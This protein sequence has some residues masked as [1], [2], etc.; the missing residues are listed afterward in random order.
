[1]TDELKAYLEKDVKAKLA[2]SI[3]EAML[4]VEESL[5]DK[6][7]NLSSK[8]IDKTLKS[9]QATFILELT[10]MLDRKLAG[11]SGDLE[12]LRA[13]V[14]GFKECEEYKRL[15]PDNEHTLHAVKNQMVEAMLELVI[16]HINPRKG[17]EKVAPM[18]M[19]GGV[20]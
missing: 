20:K 15:D 12:E 18:T 13:G 2:A 7:P 19:Q 4:E 9:A 5:R 17:Q 3:S 10:E 11:F 14:D 6:Y 1:M 8:D 16:Y